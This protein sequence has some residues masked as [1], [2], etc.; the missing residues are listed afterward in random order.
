LELETVRLIVQSVALHRL[1]ICH[2]ITLAHLGRCTH[3]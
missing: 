3:L 2:C 1:L